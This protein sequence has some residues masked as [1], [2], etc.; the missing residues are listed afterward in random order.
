MPP[1]PVA[2]T[3]IFHSR[4]KGNI[5]TNI[6][7]AYVCMYACIYTY[8]GILSWGWICSFNFLLHS[9]MNTWMVEDYMYV[10]MYV[11]TCETLSTFSTLKRLISH[12]C[13]Y[14]HKYVLHCMYACMY[15]VVETKELTMFSS[16]K[17]LDVSIISCWIMA[18]LFSMKIAI[19]PELRAWQPNLLG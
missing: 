11:F 3:M 12:V 1:F 17:R 14:V 8:D 16:L 10:C 15:W 9:C 4:K 2:V 19:S 18:T 7:T 13:M 5:Q 6:C